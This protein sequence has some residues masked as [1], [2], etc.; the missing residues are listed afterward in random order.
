MF[1]RLSRGYC[2]GSCPIYTLSVW[3]NGR[4]RFRGEG[5]VESMGVHTG[6][7]DEACVVELFH[8]FMEA[9][10]FSLPEN[11]YSH[12]VDGPSTDLVFRHG[13][14]RH[15][16]GSAG[17]PPREL[18]AAEWEKFGNAGVTL[19]DLADSV[20]RLI[21]TERWIGGDARLGNFPC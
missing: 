3:G 11:L 5:F 17:V 6:K 7:V 1:I 8:R 12:M 14:R 18:S 4:V 13:N 19:E 16:V 21:E 2:Y 9:D 20:D 10:F 15:T